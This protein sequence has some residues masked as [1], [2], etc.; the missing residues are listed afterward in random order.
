[1]FPTDAEVG[2]FERMLDTNNSGAIELEEL[3]QFMTSQVGQSMMTLQ[4][5]SI[6]VQFLHSFVYASLHITSFF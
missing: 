5:H 2:D 6:V 3:I 4:V 1:M